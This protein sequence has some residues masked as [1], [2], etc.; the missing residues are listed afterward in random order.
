MSDLALAAILA[1]TILIAST[2]SVQIGLSVALIELAA[3][4][5]VGNIFTVTVPD[6]LSF[7]GSFA[8]VVL[9]F[10]AGAEVDVPQF[11]REWKASLSI[12][13]VSFVAPFFVATAFAYWLARV[14]PR[15]GRDRRPS[16]LHD[17][18][19]G[20]L[21]RLG[22]DGPEPLADRQADHV[23]HLRHRHPDG[24]RTLAPVHHAEH[25]DRA[26]R[27]RLGG[28][29]LGLPAHR[30]LVLRPLRRSGHRARDQARLRRAVRAHVPGRSREQP[31]GAARVRARPG[32]ERPLRRTPA[33]AG[34]AAGGGLRLPD[35]VLL[36]QGRPERV[37]FGR[38]GEHRRARP[39]R[40]R[41]DGAEVRRASTR[42]RAA[43][44]RRTLPSRRCSCRPASRSAR[45]PRCTASKVGSS[46]R[47]SS[48]C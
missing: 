34:A 1:I 18:P 11:R 24:D 42:S 9:T 6:W 13:A 35:A 39:A 28:A 30:A 21:R 29:D 8:G 41:E 45:S 3:G 14:E 4:I 31:G 20:G 12:G 47:P 44:A 36:P 26:V 10:L 23:G 43:T 32:D 38:L 27:R 17:Q 40:G 33:R 7:I 22:R 15:P 37:A 46:T 2:I 5:A 19:R 48:R 25:L 16:A